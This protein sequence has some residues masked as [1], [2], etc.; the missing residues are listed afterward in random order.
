MEGG[1]NEGDACR[2]MSHHGFNGLDDKVVAATAEF[3]LR[4]R[5]R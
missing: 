1:Q 2:A 3:A 4:P 5:E